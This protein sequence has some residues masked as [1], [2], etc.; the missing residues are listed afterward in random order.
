M[1]GAWLSLSEENARCSR[2]CKFKVLQMKPSFVNDHLMG[3]QSCEKAMDWCTADDYNGQ[4]F[5]HKLGGNHMVNK[6]HL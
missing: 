1:T 2:C 6:F 3:L 5:T 4:N